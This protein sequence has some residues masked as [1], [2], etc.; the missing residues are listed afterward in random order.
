MLLRPDTGREK[1]EQV[2][3]ILDV[4]SG[5]LQPQTHRS[6]PRSGYAVI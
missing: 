5:M 4:H 2:D 1:A 6:V 3:V